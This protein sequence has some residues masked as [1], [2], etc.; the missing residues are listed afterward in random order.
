MSQWASTHQPCPCGR[1]SDAYAIDAEDGHGRCFSCGRYFK[2][3]EKQEQ[4]A[5]YTY[6]YL[7]RG[8]IAAETCRFFGAKTRVDGQGN[9]VAVVYPHPRDYQQV[10]SLVKKDFRF[11]GDVHPGG[12][13]TGL[14]PAGSAKAITVTEG[15]EDAMSV[16]QMLDKYPVYSVRSSSTALSDV[17]ADYD[18]LNSFEKIYLALDDDEPG[19]KAAAQIAAV[20]GYGKVYNVKLA[21]YKDPRDML[22]AGHEREFKTVW[23]NAR[24]FM[25]DTVVSSFSDIRAALKQKTTKIRYSWPWA[26]WQAMTGGIELHRQY[27]ISGLEG[28]GKTE[29]LH[30]IAHHLLTTYPDLNIGLLH[31]EEPLTDTVKMQVGKVVKRPIHLEEFQ[32]SDDEIAEHY[33]KLVGREDRVH[34][35]K[36][37]GSEETDVILSTMRF[38]GAACG[39]QVLLFDNYQH[40]VTG[41]T[42]DR[43]TEALDYLAN[44]TESLVKELPIAL[45]SISHE[46]DN[47]LTRGSRNITKEADVWIN[48]KRDQRAENEFTRNVQ[49][50]TFNKNRQ[51]G[52][53]GPAGKLHYD[54]AT[55]TLSEI[56]GELPT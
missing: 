50:I 3:G 26:T 39:C 5:D 38:M 42:K 9:P 14:F 15:F 4:M 20:F 45:I 43:D 25:P 7:P 53:T 2:P 34:F 22:E 33:E 27:V 19:R 6:E 36:H 29:E 32:M 24:R 47:E 1:S 46:N 44:R 41:R 8:K 51:A 16:W 54:Q 10:R 56:T 48:V 31:M 18:Y 12:F 17:R 23:Y 37:F 49:T 21:P 35:Y 28:T 40:A 11:E 13:C 52:K 30:E 55:A